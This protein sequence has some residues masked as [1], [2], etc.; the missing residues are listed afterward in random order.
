MEALKHTTRGSILVQ[1]LSALYAQKGLEKTVPRLL[2]DTLKLELFV[3]AIQFSF[4]VG[5]LRNIQLETM[6][7]TRYFDWFITTPLMLI[8]MS[9]YFLY[10]QGETAQSL[11]QVFTK[12]KKHIVRVLLFN[13]L[14]L[15]SGL[16]GELGVIPKLTA[17]ALGTAAFALVFKTIWS[18]LGGSKSRLF[19]PITTIWAMY[20]IAFMLPNLQ[21][22]TMY[23]GLDLVSKNFFAVFLAREI[24]KK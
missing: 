4:Y 22:N 12:H 3:N 21:K 2:V 20:G 24:L 14:M 5:L 19:G 23:N 6:A 13:V 11:S 7:A 17:L 18:E 1:A 8:S 9:S 16:L 15:V 10:R